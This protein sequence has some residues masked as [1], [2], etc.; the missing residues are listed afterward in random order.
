LIE[1][2]LEHTPG[3][4]RL[5]SINVLTGEVM[6]QFLV[7]EEDGRQFEHIKTCLQAKGHK[8]WRATTAAEALQF[9]QR[10]GIDLILSAIKL[11]KVDVF[12]LLREIKNTDGVKDINFVFYCLEQEKCER[13]ATDVIVNAGKALGA[14]K[15][16][17][18]Q[19]FNA[20][21]FWEELEEAVPAKAQKNDSLGGPVSTY[22][23]SSFSWNDRTQKSA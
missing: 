18:L 9:L 20:V 11:D 19:Q 5:G 15:Y 4:V 23:L 16:I 22:S 21:R 7:I 10:Y 1:A 6:A 13:Y 8:A 12:K 17:L 14:R 2:E 3:G